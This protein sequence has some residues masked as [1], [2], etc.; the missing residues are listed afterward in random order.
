MA[1]VM[2]DYFDQHYRQAL[3][4]NI[5][6]LGD[7]TPRECVKTKLGREKVISWLKDLE[8]QEEHRAKQGG[9]SAYDFSW[10]WTE[11]GLD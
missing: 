3:D 5:P 2:A 10:M 7:K 6:A 9:S 4:E 8:N 11:L 1:E